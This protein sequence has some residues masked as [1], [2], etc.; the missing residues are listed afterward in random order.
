[1]DLVR[2]AATKTKARCPGGQRL[3]LFLRHRIKPDALTF[4]WLLRPGTGR[5]P[6][7]AM[8][9]RATA[10]VVPSP[11]DQTRHLRFFMSA[12]T[13][14]RSR[15]GARDV[16]ARSGSG[17]SVA[18]GSNPTPSFFHERCDRG[19]V[20]LRKLVQPAKTLMHSGPEEH[21]FFT[22]PGGS[23]SLN[24]RPNGLFGD[25]RA[26]SRHKLH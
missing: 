15:S 12:A 21:E 20:A 11:S 9:R 23:V 7:R 6:E 25:L 1:M 2:Q 24:D 3:R 5:A 17:C 8:S 4:S 13:G 14:D 22:A 16:P 10:P 18:I 19:P 26:T